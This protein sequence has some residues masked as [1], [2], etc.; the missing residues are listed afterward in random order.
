MP[1]WVSILGFFKMP[2]LYPVC[3]DCCLQRP[4][5]H[6]LQWHAVLDLELEGK[7]QTVAC[8]M[9]YVCNRNCLN[10]HHLH[11]RRVAVLT[12]DLGL[13]LGHLLRV[14]VKVDL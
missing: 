7:Q 5:P 1:K 4:A 9:K 2:H 11:E 8:N 12:D 3:P 14:R 13:P 6:P 10:S